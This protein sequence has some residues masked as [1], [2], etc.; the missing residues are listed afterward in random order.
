[1]ATLLIYQINQW[2]IAEQ[3]LYT[4]HNF[5][6]QRKKKTVFQPPYDIPFGQETEYRRFLKRV[7]ENC[8][9]RTKVSSLCL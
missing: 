1:M 5:L 4:Y 9:L 2:S 8:L 6:A 7:Q 3:I